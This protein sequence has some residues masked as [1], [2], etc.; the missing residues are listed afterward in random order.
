MLTMHRLL[1][2]SIVIDGNV[3]FTPVVLDD[4]LNVRVLI[5]LPLGLVLSAVTDET[6]QTLHQ[7]QQDCTYLLTLPI[8]C[9]FKFG[10]NTE[11][12]ILKVLPV[13][14]D[15]DEPDEQPTWLV[16]FGINVPKTMSVYK[17]ESWLAMLEQESS[18]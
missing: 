18:Q 14:S 15:K 8:R 11:V 3:K 10:N 5:K 13:E 4:Q 6:T 17:E 16:V 2:K 12:S 7:S 9:S 1:G